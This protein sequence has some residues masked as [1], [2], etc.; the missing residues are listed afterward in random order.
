MMLKHSLGYGGTGLGTS[1]AF[2]S[3]FPS[4]V[5]G[6]SIVAIAEGWVMRVHELQGLAVGNPKEWPKRRKAV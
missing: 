2:G 4:G 3:F 5:Q 1:M 6:G